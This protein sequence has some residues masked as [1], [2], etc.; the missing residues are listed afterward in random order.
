MCRAHCERWAE[1]PFER[2]AERSQFRAQD[3]LGG[4]SVLRDTICVL[5]S[6]NLVA[7]HLRALLG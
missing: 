3:P 7:G 1:I 5:V 4:N 2:R 6:S